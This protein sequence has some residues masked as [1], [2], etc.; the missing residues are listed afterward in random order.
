MCLV[1]SMCTVSLM[2][3]ASRAEQ[4]QSSLSL[5]LQFQ[6]LSSNVSIVLELVGLD[7]DIWWLE[8]D[9]KKY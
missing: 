8:L 5:L 6:Q 7:H 9:T 3:S 4:R 1:A 2:A